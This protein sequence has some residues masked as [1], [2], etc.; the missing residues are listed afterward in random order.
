MCTSTAVRS[1]SARVYPHLAASCSVMVCRMQ[2]TP[3]VR[4]RQSR[5]VEVLARR[6]GELLGK[7]SQ[8]Y[9]RI[10]GCL[11]PLL[12]GAKGYGLLGT[13]V[14]VPGSKYLGR[15]WGA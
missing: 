11:L 4:Q 1:L 3:V 15:S 5:A 12:Q 14:L 2:I 9:R 7:H 6:L 13:P 8:P 10:R